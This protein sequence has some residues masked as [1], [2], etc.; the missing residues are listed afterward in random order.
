MEKAKVEMDLEEWE[1]LSDDGKGLFFSRESSLD[2]KGIVDVN[3]FICPSF[4]AHR[5][6]QTPDSVPSNRNQLVQVPIHLEPVVSKNPDAEF[7][8]DVGEVPMKVP[9]WAADQETISQVFFK[10]MKE[11]EFVDMKM[12]SPRSISRGLKPQIEVGPVQFEEEEEALKGED[13][14]NK[15]ESLGNGCSEG[16][17]LNIWRWRIAGIRLLSSMGV[18]AGAICIFIFAGHQ[19]HNQQYNNQKFQF[20]IFA[21]DKVKLN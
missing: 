12:D 7:V 8:K 2:P 17:G 21:E 19:R 1:I 16:G 18:A 10:K 3:Y 11:N 9:N 14:E 6:I 20:Q 4:P 5:R 13:S 15:Q